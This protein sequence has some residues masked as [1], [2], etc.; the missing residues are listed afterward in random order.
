MHCRPRGG[1]PCREDTGGSEARRRQNSENTL[2]GGRGVRLQDPLLGRA[3]TTNG[4]GNSKWQRRDP[5]KVLTSVQELLRERD[6]RSSDRGGR[7]RLGCTRMHVAIDLL[8]HLV[9]LTRSDIAIFLVVK[10]HTNFVSS[11]C[12]VSRCGTLTRPGRRHGFVRVCGWVLS[13]RSS[14]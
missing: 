2:E 6:Q 9:L 4:N 11:Y 1:G 3:P 5:P 14:K 13:L 12:P 7:G 10:P 8:Y